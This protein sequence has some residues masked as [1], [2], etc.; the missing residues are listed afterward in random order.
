M[1]GQAVAVV[2][3]SGIAELLCMLLLIVS[4]TRRLA[5][6]CTAVLFIAVFPANVRMALDAELP[7]WP[8]WSSRAT[9]I[10]LRLPLQVPLVLWAL[11]MRHS[12]I[13]RGNTD[14]GARQS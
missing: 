7:H 14:G 1:R 12:S 9:L 11:S 3:I 8:W 6:W 10:W 2:A 4:R 13:N 5:A